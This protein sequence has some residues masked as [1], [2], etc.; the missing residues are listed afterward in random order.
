V[1]GGTAR[2]VAR[3]VPGVDGISWTARLDTGTVDSA[4]ARAEL[5]VYLARAAQ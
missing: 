1:S 2:L 4:A 3:R 5:I